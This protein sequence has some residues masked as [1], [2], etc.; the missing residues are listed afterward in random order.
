MIGKDFRMKD[1]NLKGQLH[2]HIQQY[3]LDEEQNPAEWVPFEVTHQGCSNNG[4]S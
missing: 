1:S 2:F 4:R 3:Y